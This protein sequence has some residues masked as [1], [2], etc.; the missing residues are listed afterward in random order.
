MSPPSPQLTLSEAIATQPVAIFN[1]YK[2]HFK[3]Q[4]HDTFFFT[5][6][7]YEAIATYHLIFHVQGYRHRKIFSCRIT[8]I[9]TNKEALR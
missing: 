1:I 9:T 6:L 3:V 2:N 4:R 5:T 7:L 8:V